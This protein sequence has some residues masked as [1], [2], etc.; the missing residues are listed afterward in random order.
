MSRGEQLEKMETVLNDSMSTYDGMILRERGY[1]LDRRN[2]EGSE[3]AVEEAY[4]GTPYDEAGTGD[5]SEGNGYGGTNDGYA[6][7]ASGGGT[8]PAGPGDN[9]QGE[10]DNTQAAAAPPADIPSGD[11]DDVVA[12]QIREAAMR[13]TDP[14]LREKLWDEYR[15]Y[16]KNQS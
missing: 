3:Q 16:K 11:D 14:E 12:R 4:S 2:Q 9:R 15:K 5:E 7:T 10:Y 1:V 6:S 13:E 8:R